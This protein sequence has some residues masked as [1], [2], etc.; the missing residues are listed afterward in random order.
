MITA[1]PYEW[2]TASTGPGTWSRT[3]AMYA[4]S[5]EMPRNGFAG[6][7][8]GT[9]FARSRVATGLQLDPS[10]NA[11]CTSTTVGVLLITNPLRSAVT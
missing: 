10:A 9:P 11:P 5:L 6:T 1:P 8:T 3:L 4:E 7:V 2:P